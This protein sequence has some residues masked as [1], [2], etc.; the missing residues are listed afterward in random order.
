MHTMR[1]PS[2]IP[3]RRLPHLLGAGLLPPS[4]TGCLFEPQA[5]AI[6][7]GLNKKQV[8]PSTRAHGA[9]ERPRRPSVRRGRVQVF[10]IMHV[11]VCAMMPN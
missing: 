10:A 11:D 6:T 9:E 8:G 2:A 5:T 3:R 7:I 1:K 4:L